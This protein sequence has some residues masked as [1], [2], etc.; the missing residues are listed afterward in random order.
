MDYSVHIST[1][2]IKNTLAV[3]LGCQRYAE[4]ILHCSEQR[5]HRHSTTVLFMREAR[6]CDS[7]KYYLLREMIVYFVF[8][9]NNYLRFRLKNQKCL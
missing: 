7:L 1:W 4:N 9:L 6:H 5:G 8:V 3:L 2:K